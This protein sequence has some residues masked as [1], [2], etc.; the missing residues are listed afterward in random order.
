MTVI[1]LAEKQ[2]QKL[3]AERKEAA[4]D[5]RLLAAAV[6]AGTIAAY[7]LV[8]EERE[9]GGMRHSFHGERRDFAIHVVYL[10]MIAP[11]LLFNRTG[12][13]APPLETL[14]PQEDAKSKEDQSP[15]T[16]E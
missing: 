14:I 13:Q 8:A 15:P 10:Q 3:S 1:S 12:R 9:G 6:E 7:T 16:D 5:L 11:D 4:D 2:A